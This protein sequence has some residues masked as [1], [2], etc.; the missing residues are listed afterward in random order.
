M[1][2]EVI[3]TLSGTFTTP[4]ASDLQRNFSEMVANGTRAVAMEVSSHALSLGRVN[5]TSFAAC[6]FTN[7][8]RDHLDF[9]GSEESYFE[10]KARLFVLASI[11]HMVFGG[12][13]NPHLFFT[14]CKPLNVF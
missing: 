4:E 11:E 10:A 1:Q 2:T 7:L 5:G 3:G 8:G 14:I 13:S 6:V 12:N 9:H